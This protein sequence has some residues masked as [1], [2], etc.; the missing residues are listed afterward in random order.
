M[1]NYKWAAG[2]NGPP[3]HTEH[4]LR[5]PAQK[6]DKLYFVNCPSVARFRIKFGY[7]LW[8]QIA[9]TDLEGSLQIILIS[10]REIFHRTSLLRSLHNRTR[11]FQMPYILHICGFASSIVQ[12]NVCLGQYNRGFM[13]VELLLLETAKSKR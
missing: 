9:R 5:D 6:F 12:S 8:N 7:V 3:L 1:S 10:L 4:T 2:C 13:L 11:P